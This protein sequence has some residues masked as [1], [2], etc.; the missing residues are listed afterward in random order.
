MTRLYALVCAV[1]ACAC[2]PNPGAA[3]HADQAHTAIVEITQALRAAK[4]LHDN[5]EKQQA[6]DHWTQAET[7]YTN[8][9]ESGVAFHCSSSQALQLSYLLG[10][11][12]REIDHPKGMPAQPMQQLSEQFAAILTAIPQPAPQ[13]EKP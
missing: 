1:A 11:I 8:Q 2:A 7:T 9:L 12:A 13:P 4:S 5:G 3:L 6:R 10:H